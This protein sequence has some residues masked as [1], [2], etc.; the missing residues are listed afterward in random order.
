VL[1]V[2]VQ[3]M[4]R[5]AGRCDYADARRVISATEHLSTRNGEVETIAAEASDG[6]GVR[7]RAGG[8]WGFASSSDPSAA[9]AQDALRRALAVAEAQP[10]VP[11]ARLAPTPPAR[12]HWQGPCEH[13]PFAVPIEAKLELLLAADALLRGDPRIARATAQCLSARTTKAFASTEGA[14]CTQTL[15]ECGAGIQAAAVEGDELQVRS[16]PGA[17][18]GGVAAAGWEQV[19]SL[20]LPGQ[21]PRVADEALAL[22]SAPACPAGVR[23]VI[24]HGEQAALQLH[25]S[26]GHALELD[27]I[28]GGELSYA[29]GSWVGVEDLGS[30]RY[31]SEALNVTADAR[32]PGGLGSFGWDDEGVAARSLPLIREGRLQ[33]ALSGR[34]SAAAAGLDES[35]GCARAD[36]HARQPIVRMTNVSL[37][38]GGA[39]S[40]AD[41]IADTEDGLYLE[42]N[43]SWSIDDRR[44][45]FQF[46]TEVAREVRDG[47]LGRLYRNPSY[48]GVTPR[49]WGSLDAVCGPEEWRLWGLLNCGKGEPGQVMHVSHGTA[50]ARFRD[51]QVGVA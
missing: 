12:G 19:E 42:T 47:E 6:I 2:L 29:G 8:A 31:G 43:R 46:A 7:V 49:F 48:A 39:R 10:R 24:L 11:Q 51:V 25:E 26:I 18:E 14:A 23:T 32:A 41:L 33:T 44:L 22:L 17:H 38:P 4:E 20:D 15:T 27:R 45:H 16:F 35:G 37:E 13:D 30:L 3:T 9:G 21:A 28:L 5:A 34:E 36:G 40:L 1:D 50:P